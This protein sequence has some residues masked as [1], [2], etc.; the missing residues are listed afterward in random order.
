MP[1][2]PAMLPVLPVLQAASAEER[3]GAALEALMWDIG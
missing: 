3:A 2:L 1:T